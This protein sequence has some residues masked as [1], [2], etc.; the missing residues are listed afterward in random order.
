MYYNYKYRL[1]PT[2]EQ[3]ETMNH[4]LD[5]HRW[6]YNH[7]LEVINRDGQLPYNIL[8]SDL[9]Y[10]KDELQEDKFGNEY[11]LNDVHAQSLAYTL[12]QLYSNIM[13][14]SGTKK[15]NKKNI[16]K[17][18][19]KRVRKTGK[20]RFKSKDKFKSFT[21]IQ[22][23]FEII[24]D[25][26]IIEKNGCP[27]PLY[28]PKRLQILR[29]SKI[30][31]IP[32]RMNRDI[33]NEYIIKKITIKRYSSG[34]WYAIFSIHPESEKKAKD[35]RIEEIRKKAKEDKD[36]KEYRKKIDILK[37]ILEKKDSKDLKITAIDLGIINYL[38]DSDGNSEPHPKNIEKSQEKLKKEQQ[39][40]A[41]KELKEE[42]AIDKEGNK[43]TKKTSSK[44]RDKQKKKVSKMHKKIQDRRDDFEHKKSRKYIDNNDILIYEDLNIYNLMQISRNARNIADASWGKL[45]R[46]SEYKA[47]SA[48]KLVIKVDLRNTSQRCSKCGKIAYKPLYIRTHRCPYCGL[49]LDR[50]Y[51]SSLDIKRL[52]II[53]IN[54]MIME[55][56]KERVGKLLSEFKPLETQP[57]AI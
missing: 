25:C 5:I 35:E 21:Y 51:N 19:Y 49:V 27:I 38:Y 14:L 42:E 52:G 16:E 31:D 34:E 13:R 1:Y 50:D 23:G 24:Y 36:E 20:L 57:L 10:L 54:K 30:G 48:G 44:N 6:T 29:L 46:M 7:F 3:V 18:E 41:K 22:K 11:D 33:P 4:H 55:I 45:I 56:N 9:P 2:E 15:K 26:N 37:N 39:K 12:Q 28:V 17:G 47:E 8:S 32:I 53:E 40:F 43:Y